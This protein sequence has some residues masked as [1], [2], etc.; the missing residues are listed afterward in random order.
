MRII[1]LIENLVYERDLYAEHG[2]ALYIETSDKKILFDTGQS[3]TFLKNAQT[4][5]IDIM[6]IDTVIISHGHFDHT[7]G[8]YSFLSINNKAKVYIKKEAFIHKYHGNNKYIGIT[9]DSEILNGRVE[10]VNQVTEIDKGIYIMPD[11]PIINKIDTNFH[12]FKISKPN[13]FENDEFQDELFLA[14]TCNNELSIISSC[15]H[16]GITN[17]VNAAIN[18]FKLPV[19]LILGGFH[20]KDCG[21]SQYTAITHYLGQIS[22]KSIGI[23]HC[24]GIEKY[25]DLLYQCNH[26]VFYNFTGNEIKI[27]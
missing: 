8:L 24:T 15:S 5:G 17:I 4:M 12:H 19:N 3:C 14:I 22:P 23:C 25:A 10:Y 21:T 11:I 13:G 18:Y 1:T 6:E 16:R 27:D 20:I 2:L 9:Y 26:K 7:G